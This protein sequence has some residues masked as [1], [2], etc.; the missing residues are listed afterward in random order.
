MLGKKLGID[1]GTGTVRVLSRGDGL[2]VSEPAVVAVHGDG[3]HPLVGHAAVEA[4]GEEGGA[5]LMR[6][7]A[8]G[9]VVDGPGLDALLQHVINRAVGRQRIFKPDVVVG[10][11]SGMSGDSR[12]AVLAAACTAGARTAYL[13][14]APAAAA[15]GA[16]LSI[17][18]PRAQMV[19]D[20]GAGKVDVAVLALEGTVASRS[21]PAGFDALLD[22]VAAVVVAQGGAPI[23][24]A[25]LLQ[26]PGLVAALPHEERTAEV[27]GVLV[28]SRDLERIV[29]AHLDA[30]E[31]AALDVLEETPAPLRHDISAFGI[32]LTGGGALQ[33]GLDR[34]LAAV[35]RMPVKVADEPR[36]CVV[37]GAALAVDHLDVLKRSF[38]YIR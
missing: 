25:T 5:R 9:E 19:V 2:S 38:L 18:S 31:R 8:G 28:S 16:N 13:L 3:R 7:V 26:F 34:H 15:I 35:T 14:D 33:E 22:A 11:R 27:G 4:A 17:N 30:L 1:L 20:I 37:R 12:R 21:L 32:T 24:P 36:M 10:V 6:P 29:A 23:A